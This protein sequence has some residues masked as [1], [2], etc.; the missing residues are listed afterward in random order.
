MRAGIVGRLTHSLPLTRPAGLPVYL[1][2]VPA[3]PFLRNADFM[4]VSGTDAMRENDMIVRQGD[5]KHGPG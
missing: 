3:T 4:S 5:P 1:A 2:R